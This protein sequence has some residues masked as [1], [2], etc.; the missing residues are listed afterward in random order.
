MLELEAGMTRRSAPV[1]SARYGRCECGPLQHEFARGLL[2][3]SV[4]LER[5][6]QSLARPYISE[7]VLLS[8]VI[9]RSYGE[10]I[11]CA[12]MFQRRCPFCSRDGTIFLTADGRR[13][14]ST[15]GVVADGPSNLALIGRDRA[16]DL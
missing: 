7:R 16:I 3:G 10:P 8:R 4:Q 15:T 13:A 9:K 11:P 6:R 2:S 12:W 1:L 5:Q 14:C